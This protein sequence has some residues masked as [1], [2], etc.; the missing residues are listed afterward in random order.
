MPEPST[1]VIIAMSGGVDSSVAAALLVEQG[2]EVT[3]IMLRLWSECGREAENRCCSPD[4]MAIARQVAAR[5]DIPFYVVDAQQ[6]HYDAVVRTF[7]DGYYAGYTPNPCLSCNIHIRWGFLLQHAR[8]L[9]ADWMATGHYA[10][11]DWQDNR[12]RLLVAKDSTKDQSY[13]LHSLTQNQLSQ[14]LFPLG[15]LTKIEVRQIA[16]EHGLPAA[17]RSESQDLCFLGGEDYRNFLL[18]IAPQTYKTRTDSYTRR[19]PPGKPSRPGI[20]YNWTAERDRNFITG[21]PLC[22]S[23]RPGPKC[24]DCRSAR[25]AR[26][27]FSRCWRNK[28]GRWQPTSISIPG[29]C[30]NPLHSSPGWGSCQPRTKPA[31]LYPAQRAFEGYYTRPGS[32]FLSG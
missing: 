24:P 17:E 20:L 32:R 16:R 7:I 2:Y 28:L 21:T 25:S 14:T 1:K 15:N 12:L 10:R 8:L 6:A 22:A 11:L 4:S 18:R 3:G 23:K 26:L 13:V 30:E 27:R 9:G 29:R 31:S 5:L 19:P